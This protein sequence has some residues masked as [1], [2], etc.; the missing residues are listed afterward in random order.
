MAGGKLADSKEMLFT[1]TQRS[2]SIRPTANGQV[3]STTSGLE[4]FENYLWL[5]ITHILTGYDH[6]AFVLCLILIARTRRRAIWLISGFTIGHS[7]TLALAALGWVSPNG[8]IVE[9]LIGGSIALVAAETILARQNKMPLIGAYAAALLFI[10]SG[11]GVFLLPNISLAVWG[12]LILFCLCYGMAI[13]DEASADRFTPIMTIAFGLVHGFGF[14]GLLTDIGL[15]ADRLLTGLF[16][17]NLGVELGQLLVL[18]PALIFGPYILE[19]L[20]KFKISWSDITAA[21]LTALGIYLFVSRM[22]AG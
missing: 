6:L 9:A 13:R 18:G 3:E 17:F 10:I 14:A 15:P 2:L 8:Q 5:G 20:P 4:T 11:L 12:G 1:A 22:I 19:E 7:L 16:S 21:A